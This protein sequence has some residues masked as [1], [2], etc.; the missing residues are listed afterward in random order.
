[1]TGRF[2]YLAI[3]TVALA[4]LAAGTAPLRAAPPEAYPVA[5]EIRIGGDDNQTRLIID[6]TRKVDL[7][8]FTLAD[9]YRV[10]IDMPQVTFAL[11]AE[12]GR[13]AGAV[14][15]RRIAMAS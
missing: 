13:Q 3:I 6:L 4:A 8:V 11:A 12:S 9:P 7:R 10:V 5:T 14:W 2:G 15:S 1:M